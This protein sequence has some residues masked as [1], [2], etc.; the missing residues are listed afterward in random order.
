MTREDRILWKALPEIV[1]AFGQRAQGVFIPLK[2]GQKVAIPALRQ[3]GAD[4]VDALN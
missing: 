2:I 3:Y 4:E 1:S